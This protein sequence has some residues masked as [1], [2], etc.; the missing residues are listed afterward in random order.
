MYKHLTL[1]DRCNIEKYLTFGFSLTEI[2]EKIGKS[3]TSVSREIRKH[4]IIVTGTNAEC[5]YSRKCERHGVC[6]DQICKRKCIKCTGHDCK[7]LC[8]EYET[9]KCEQLDMPPYVCTGCDKQE[10]CTMQHA[11]YNAHKAHKSYL[12][13]LSGSRK[14]LHIS[15]EELSKVNGLVSPLIRKG[16]SL[17]HIYA[18]HGEE[19]GVSRKTL[20]NYIDKAAL[21]VCNLDLPRKVRYRKRKSKPKKQTEYKYRSGRTYKDFKSFMELHPQ[22]GYVEMDTV[23]GRREKG[24][25]LLTMIFTEWE[26][27]LIFLL[28]SCTQECVAEVFETLTKTFGI[29]RFHHLFPVILTDNGSEFKDPET[30]EHSAGGVERTHIFYCD[31]MASYQKGSIEVAHEF[32][33]RII[34]KGMSFDSLTQ[35]DVTLMMNHINSVK[36]D[37][38]DGLS[39][40]ETAQKHLSKSMTALFKFELIPPDEIVLKPSLL[41]K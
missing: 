9:A 29:M 12:D 3:Q 6:G 39:P 16:Q 26:L 36:R 11:Y 35:E 38:L 41:E 33:R 27:L 10:I 18:T 17:S 21:D 2:G 31:A 32:I 40:I 13:S 20:Y 34:P 22:L 1:T 37:S 23:H 24:K 28:D 8:D 5:I 4:R 19:I 7:E 14:H 25:C 15:N 30:L